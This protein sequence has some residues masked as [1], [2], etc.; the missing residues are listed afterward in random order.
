MIEATAISRVRIMTAA[1]DSNRVLV[2]V[3]LDVREWPCE[4][5]E[6]INTAAKRGKKFRD[7]LNLTGFER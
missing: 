1:A 6:A 2:R 7:A 4:L 5:N 3:P